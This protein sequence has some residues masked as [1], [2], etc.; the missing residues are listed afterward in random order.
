MVTESF[1]VE[2][3]LLLEGHE[4]EEDGL[5]VG[6]GGED[7]DG[8]GE[9]ALALSE[10]GE[11]GIDVADLGGVTAFEERDHRYQTVH[12]GLVEGGG[13]VEQEVG[14]LLLGCHSRGCI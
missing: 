13:L 2:G 3:E 7:R 1:P 14:D 12:F 8:I 6:D 5:I 9:E 4:D 11:D 10:L